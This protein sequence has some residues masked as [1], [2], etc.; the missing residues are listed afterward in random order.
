MLDSRY[1]KAFYERNVRDSRTSAELVFAHVLNLIPGVESAVDVG[2]G[3]GVWLSV[4]REKGIGAVQ[5]YDG[6]WVLSAEA[7]TIP[8]DLFQPVDLNKPFE[9]TRRYDLAVSVEVAEHLLPASSAGFVHS[10]TQ[11]SDVVL[12][13]AAVPGQGGVDHINE[14]WPEFWFELFDKEHYQVVDVL[15]GLIWDDERVCYWYRQN[16]FLFLRRETKAEL[17]KSLDCQI[18]PIVRIVHPELLLFKDKFFL[19]NIMDSNLSTGQAFRLFLLRARK[20][21]ERRI[22]LPRT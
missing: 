21:I 18:R 7:L 11:L 14:Q 1:D 13:S 3:T 10:L 4:L 5:G 16:L 8:R 6:E 20:A 2:C 9:I 15:R 22:R 17:I 19:P 12:F